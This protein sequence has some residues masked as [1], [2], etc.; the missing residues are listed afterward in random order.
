MLNNNNNNNNFVHISFYMLVLAPK[1][2][3]IN[4]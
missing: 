4:T 3:A 2:Q 1:K